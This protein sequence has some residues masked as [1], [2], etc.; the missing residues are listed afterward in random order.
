MILGQ[1][2]EITAR[3]LAVSLPNNLTGYVPL[4]SISKRLTEKIEKLLQDEEDE[5]QDQDLC[6]EKPDD[7]DLK[8]YFRVGQYLRTYVTSTD[9]EP[10]GKTSRRRIELSLDP[11]L[12]NTGLAKSDIVVSATIQA[13]V[14]SV[15]DYGLVMDIGLDDASI[16]GFVSS[17]EIG[18]DVDYSSVKEG[19]VFLCVVTG[20]NPSGTVVKLSADHK[21]ANQLTKSHY[22]SSAPSINTFLPGTAVEIL[23]SEVTATGIA[24]KV[25]GLLDVTADL[26]HS[27]ARAAASDLTKR[28]QAGAKI[29]G[30]LL[31][32]FPLS[33]TKK[34][35]FSLLDHVVELKAPESNDGSHLSTVVPKAEVVM[36]DPGLGLYVNLKAEADGF[37]HIS[38]ISDGRIESLSATDGPFKLGSTHKARIIGYNTIDH[39][40]IVSLQPKVI[41]QPYLRVEDVKVGEIAKGT[42]E[43]IIPGSKGIE[44]LLV[45]L[46]DNVTG[47]VPRIHMSDAQLQYPERKFKEG[48]SVNTRVL[49]INPER[50]QIR[51]TLKKSLLNSE[52]RIW[53]DYADV[54]LAQQCPGTLVKVSPHGA[55]V[56]FFGTVRG[57]LPVSEMS[58]AYIKDATE[59]FREGQVISAHAL[60]IDQESRKITL[61]CKDPSSMTEDYREAFAK[62]VPG[63]IVA[64]TVFEKSDDDLLLRLEASNL[65]ARLEE[66]HIRDGSSKK[67][68]SAMDKIRVGQRLQ[69]LLVLE[70]Q[71]KRRLIKLSNKASLIKASENGT[72]LR[73]LSDLREGIQLE[74]FVRNITSEG[75]FVEFAAG[76]NG[77]IPKTQVSHDIAEQPDF[78][79]KM[80]QAISATVLSIDSRQAKP[81]F[82]MT[83]KEDKRPVAGSAQQHETATTDDAITDPVDEISRAVEDFAVG[84]CTKAR[85]LSI[86]DT[87]INVELAKDIQG[88]VDVSELYDRWEDIKNPKYPMNMFKLKQ[89]LDVRIL[90]AHDARNHRFLPI[91]HRVGR[92]PVFELSAKPHYVAA[93]DPRPLTLDQVTIGSSWTA[94]VNNFGDDCLWVNI[95]PNVR[96]R[97]RAIDLAEDLSLLSNLEKSF[98]LGSALRVH[99]TGIDLDKNRLDL[100]AKQSGLSK[101]STFRDVSRGQIL[102]GRIT[103][104][105]DRQ[106]LVQLSENIV[107]AVSL[108]DMADDYSL[109]NT[110]NFRKNEVIRVCV[111]DIDLPNKKMALSIRPSRVLS[112]TSPVTDREISGFDELAVGDIVRGFV[113]N[114]SD[115]GVFITLGH[116]V[117]AFVRVTNLSDEFLKEWKD[118]FQKDQLV[119][120][121]ITVIDS[122]NKQVQISLKGSVLKDDYKPPITFTDLKVGQIVTGKV[123]SVQDFGV[124]IVVDGSENVRGLCHRSEMAEQ[125]VEDVRKLYSEGDVVKAKII[126]LEPGKRR[127]NFGLKASY[128]V[129]GSTET[130]MA[131]SD[132]DDESEDDHAELLDGDEDNNGVSL[133]MDMLRDEVLD[134][135]DDDEDNEKPGNSGIDESLQDDGA[136]QG[137]ELDLSDLASQSGGISTS[138]TKSPGI[139]KSTEPKGLLT[140]GFD[141]GGNVLSA[142][143]RSPSPSASSV[144]DRPRKKKKKRPQIMIDHTGDLDAHGPHSTSDFE[145][146]LLSEPDSSNLWLQYMAFHLELGDVDRARELAERALKTIGL[147]QDVEKQN[148]WIALL[149]LE[150]TYGDDDSVEEVFKRAC[151]YNDPQEIHERLSSIYIQ[152]GKN[153]VILLFSVPGAVFIS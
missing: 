149:N 82:W 118:N 14:T 35:G 78:G 38:R 136:D 67:R 95:S 71:Q 116:G 20:L 26:V 57:F 111:L 131:D 1:I 140:G 65:T 139:V 60:N 81:R 2:S 40:Y 122:V 105:T 45:N 120:G 70:A 101:D 97:I 150:N 80:F 123:A 25:M 46:A 36:V 129:D 110:N 74:G 17:K 88:R 15:E 121:R 92:A 12:T 127:V 50:K 148:V 23:L 89:I 147:S 7:T 77:L 64:G 66:G 59:H 3:D 109:I 113:S 79:L 85:I 58:E 22:L 54:S 108:L 84:K 103:K 106:F 125:R 10:H 76:L 98:P 27:G 134:D 146:L 31:Y 69:G 143:K 126:K 55:I 151:Q 153:E 9:D 128:L 56:Q 29:K 75:V 33:E 53:K 142:S 68:R 96:G 124:F 132:E 100:S 72:L 99:V 117:T 8:S 145:R 137:V 107:G 104:V 93:E 13:A 73:N 61:S 21:R 130:D 91:S 102:L 62:V 112:S 5:E 152:S 6:T 115:A 86:R 11:Q 133:G 19:A 48:L 63:T 144:E 51:L 135:E 52:A 18:R 90:G 28:Y 43:K 39:L 32:N 141:W 47:L 49:S 37:V 83:M 94:F 30:R 41:D 114:V 138:T 119:K 87:Q 16:R 34:L 4:T 44:G 24:G 42:I